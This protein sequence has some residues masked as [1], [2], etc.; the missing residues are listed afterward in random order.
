MGKKKFFKSIIPFIF[1]HSSISQLDE[2][3]YIKLAVMRSYMEG[4]RQE[5][6]AKVKDGDVLFLGMTGS[7]KST[8]I[9]LL[10]GNKVLKKGS[11]TVENANR[12]AK[13][14]LDK[15]SSTTLNIDAYRV[16]DY[17]Y[18]DSPGF[19]GNMTLDENLISYANYSALHGKQL[20]IVF[21]V[22]SSNDG[23]G[24]KRKI[25]EFFEVLGVSY[26]DQ[27][28][29]IVFTKDEEMNY[30]NIFEK[31]NLEGF[32][33]YAVLTN[34]RCIESEDFSND[35][36][37]LEDLA[38]IRSVIA[39]TPLSSVKIPTIASFLTDVQYQDVLDYSEKLAVSMV[40]ELYSEVNKEEFEYDSIVRE[41][42]YEKTKALFSSLLYNWFDGEWGIKLKQK[43]YAKIQAEIDYSFIIYR[44]AIYDTCKIWHFD[45]ENIYSKSRAGLK[46]HFLDNINDFQRGVD[47]KYGSEEYKQ[48]VINSRNSL[49]FV[50]KEVKSKFLSVTLSDVKLDTLYEELDEM[51]IK[52]YRQ[53]SIAVTHRKVYLNEV[54]ERG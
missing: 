38:E 51:W 3:S 24:I 46:Q 6:S 31:M 9:S 23:P 32:S 19:K 21:V 2:S 34:A 37:I 17:S 1:L 52:R 43:V 36:I 45:S 39:E 49:P 12:S 53:N 15:G 18:I 28:F 10:L 40:P 54:M 16:G 22:T 44:H 42:T 20:K 25:A 50:S 7:G 30:E 47:I 26:E 4:A 33:R 13:P 8:L 14:F 35:S 5:A 11:Y 48:K 27:K 41:K 29:S